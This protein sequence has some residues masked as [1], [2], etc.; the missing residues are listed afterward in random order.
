MVRLHTAK[1][2]VEDFAGYRLGNLDKRSPHYVVIEEQNLL[3]S[4]REDFAR[5]Q[6]EWDMCSEEKLEL[7]LEMAEWV[8]ERMVLEAIQEI[9]KK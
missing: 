4:L 9:V 7:G 8:W 1:K 3:Y 5:D 2:M 6:H